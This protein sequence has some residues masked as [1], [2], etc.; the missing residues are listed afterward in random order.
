MAGTTTG[1]AAGST[2]IDDEIG[3]SMIYPVAHRL[4]TKC[5]AIY[6]IKGASK[7]ADMDI[8]VAHKHGLTVYFRLEDIRW[9]NFIVLLPAN[10]QAIKPSPMGSM[11]LRKDGERKRGQ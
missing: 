11:T 5:D 2:A 9:R 8:D 10:V 4:I 6:R 7:G 1:K 3:E